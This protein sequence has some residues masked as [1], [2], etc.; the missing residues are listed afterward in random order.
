[1]GYPLSRKGGRSYRTG[2]Q[3]VAKKVKMVNE[4]FKKRVRRAMGS[5]MDKRYAVWNDIASFTSG[6]SVVPMSFNIIEGDNVFSERQGNKITPTALKLKYSWQASGAVDENNLVRLMIFQWKDDDNSNPPSVLNEFVDVS[7]QGTQNFPNT[8]VWFAG[9]KNFHLVY[10]SG[11]NAVNYQ[12]SNGCIAKNVNLYAKK[13]HNIEF[14]TGSRG[15]NNLYLV[16][17]SD[18]AVSP[19][20]QLRIQAQLEYNA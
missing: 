2:L 13:L 11:V 17:M 5:V 10:D 16:A 7:T 3:K 12:T 4:N 9:H 15:W 8:Q 6:G 14:S 1:M 18:S 19:H 20:P